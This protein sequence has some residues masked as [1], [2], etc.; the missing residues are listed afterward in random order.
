MST[1][2]NS[3]QKGQAVDCLL[4][5]DTRDYASQAGLLT[6]TAVQQP[7]LTSMGQ[8]SAL[9]GASGRVV[10]MIPEQRGVS[11]PPTGVTPN[12]ASTP[13]TTSTSTGIVMLSQPQGLPS[14]VMRT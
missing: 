11:P 6:L 14:Q 3:S 13:L 2:Q 7:G 8:E 12:A 5:E 4:A 9:R 10:S 1:E